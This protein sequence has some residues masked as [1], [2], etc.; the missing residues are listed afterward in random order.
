MP[1]EPVS[2]VGPSWVVA[3][4]TPT[5]SGPQ[6]VRQAGSSRLTNAVGYFGWGYATICSPG[7]G[8]VNWPTGLCTPSASPSA[9]I[10]V[11]Q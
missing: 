1:T 4:S 8:V 2:A 11:T 5:S 7:A 3:A 10:E 9:P 6:S